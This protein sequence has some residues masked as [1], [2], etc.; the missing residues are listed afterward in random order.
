LYATTTTTTIVVIFF[1][2]KNTQNFPKGERGKKKAPTPN[3][4]LSSCAK[5]GGQKLHQRK[6][7]NVRVFLFTMDVVHLCPLPKKEKY[8]QHWIL[9][10]IN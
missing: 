3:I 2:T 7:C 5:W 9:Y 4:V 1:H 6:V 10:L 8:P